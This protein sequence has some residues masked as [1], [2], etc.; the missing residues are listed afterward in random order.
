MQ[1]DKKALDG[2]LTLILARG[3]GQSF[4]A[5]NADAHMVRETL[6]EA[7]TP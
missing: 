5:A 7:L 2:K 4:V 1:K 6:A 3:I